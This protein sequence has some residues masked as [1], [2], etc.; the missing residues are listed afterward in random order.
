[1][2]ARIT[3]AGKRLKGK[4]WRGEASQFVLPAMKALPDAR[5]YD[6][7]TWE[8]T[9]LENYVSYAQAVPPR[10]NSCYPVLRAAG[11]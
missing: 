4:E 1:M 10:F 8:R 9:I 11:G 2:G 6:E 3:R 5:K 7:T